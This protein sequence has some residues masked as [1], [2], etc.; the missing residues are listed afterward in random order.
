MK[1]DANE[2]M[3]FD[4]NK[5]IVGRFASVI[6][7]NLLNGK[8]VAVI[9][10]EKALISGN[11]NDLLKKYRT[12][13]NIK[14]TMNPENSPYWSKKPDILMKRIIRGMLPYKSSHGKEAYKRLKVFISVPEIFKD[15]SCVEMVSK[16]T[17]TMYMN[18]M[19]IKE[20][21]ELLGYKEQ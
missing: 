14:E 1:I 5:K 2:Y 12:R 19:S 16:D 20:L 18:T 9:N 4:A 13:L 8:T 21:S 7:K 3:V 17:K 6:A 10:A 11:K 15:K